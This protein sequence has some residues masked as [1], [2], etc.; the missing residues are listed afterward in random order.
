MMAIILNKTGSFC[1]SPFPNKPNKPRYP[2]I[3]NATVTQTRN[4]EKP[5][6][7]KID[8]NNLTALIP[9]IIDDLIKSS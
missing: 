1:Q 2:I 3:K 8:K 9:F 4:E 6:A 5:M 7:A